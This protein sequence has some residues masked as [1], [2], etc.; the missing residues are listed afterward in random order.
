MKKGS[1]HLL[2]RKDKSLFA[3]NVKMKDM[4]GVELVLA[5]G[6]ILESG[7]AS[8]RAR[9]TVKHFSSSDNF[10]AF[11]VPTPTVPHYS[12]VFNGAKINGSVSDD[13]SSNGST[14]SVTDPIEGE[15]SVPAPPSMAPPPPPEELFFLPPPEFMG[16]LN[17]LRP[18]TPSAK[19]PASQFVSLQEDN[20][21]FLAPPPMTPP[22][23]QSTTSSGSVPISSPNIPEHPKYAPPQPPP[24]KPKSVKHPPPKPIRISSVQSMDSPPHTPAPPPPVHTPTLSTFNPQS[25]A[26]LYSAPK[27]TFLNG[28]E[29]P[30]PKI[31]P[32]L[33][34]EDTGAGP[35]QT[36][37]NGRPKSANVQENIKAVVPKPMQELREIETAPKIRIPAPPSMPPPSSTPP[38]PSTLPLP[39]TPPLPS[40]QPSPTPARKPLTAASLKEINKPTPS[41]PL[42]KVHGLQDA[43]VD[44][45]DKPDASS[46]SLNGKY[47]PLLDRKLRNLSGPSAPKDRSPLALL[48]AAKQRDKH[49]S[50]SHEN[51]DANRNSLLSTN[52]GSSL[53][54]DSMEGQPESPMS[55]PIYAVPN[56]TKQ[57]INPVV[58]SANFTPSKSA[59][60]PDFPSI[61][62]EFPKADNIKADLDVPFLPPPPE[63]VD[64]E[65]IEPPPSMPPPDPPKKAAPSPM[66][67]PPTPPKEPVQTA[68]TTPVIQSPSKPAIT[69]PPPPKAPPLHLDSTAKSK[70]PPVLVKPKPA[71]TPLPTPTTPSQATLLNILKK[72]MMEMDQKVSS[73]VGEPESNADDWG[74]AEDIEVTAMP[75]VS[76]PKSPMVNKSSL[77]MKELQTK[78]TKKHTEPNRIPIPTSNGP[79]KHQYGMTFTVRPG[80]KQPITLVSKGDP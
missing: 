28:Y 45:L 39:S 26:K 65:E 55:E 32:K 38:P 5:S 49:R 29:E 15:I 62:S 34:L 33:L 16:D 43:K 68:I 8:V 11:A 13:Q 23:P 64:F 3:T 66:Y 79:S 75:K 2:G 27:S 42:L 18:P 46:P 72:K 71:P 25:P 76:L 1:L 67:V 69:P 56:K 48:M 20:F 40:M 80:T 52:S 10:Q 78:V 22:K 17:T 4:D 54:L 30:G 60:E 21:N 59:V 51:S 77:D 58:P 14:I 35:L 31:K 24:E 44:R 47:S 37:T 61:T 74:S 73:D 41:S 9:P 63:F 36:N 70:P 12:P 7:T 19:K 6:S 50:S 53:S 57:A